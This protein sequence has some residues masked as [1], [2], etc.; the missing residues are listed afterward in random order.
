MDHVGQDLS[1]LTGAELI[2]EELGGKLED[3]PTANSEY[4]TTPGI[5]LGERFGIHPHFGSYQVEV[6]FTALVDNC[7]LHRND[8]GEGS[9]LEETVRTWNGEGSGDPSGAGVP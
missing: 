5:L 4:P 2:T 3:L 8:H 1:V 7:W 6:F 9:V